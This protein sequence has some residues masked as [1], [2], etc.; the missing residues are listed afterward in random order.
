[1][2]NRTLKSR[3]KLASI[4]D[5]LGH[6]RRIAILQVLRQAGQGGI[7]F[8]DLALRTKMAESVLKHHVRMMKRGGF[9][10]LSSKGKFTVLMLDTEQLN[11][12]LSSI[13]F[14]KGQDK[15]HG[16]SVFRWE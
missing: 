1:M 5:A 2:K 16:L 13:V 8:G 14:E 4:F 6:H 3:K 11:M 9:L 15:K 7:T 10:R 12:A